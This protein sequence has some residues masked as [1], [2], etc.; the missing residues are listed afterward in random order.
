MKKI[1]VI[2]DDQ[3]FLQWVSTGLS[4]ESFEVVTAE[5]GRGGLAL[6]EAH[7]PDLVIVDLYLPDMEGFDICHQLKSNDNTKHI[8]VILITGVFKN[9]NAI[10][11]GYQSGAD[12]FLMKPFSYEQL[13]IRVLRQFRK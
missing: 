3:E 1:V 10:D 8:P 12:D 6:V 13:R 5:N 7:M 2:D 9:I 11:K 4:N